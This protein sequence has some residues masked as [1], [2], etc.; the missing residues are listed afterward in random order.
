MKDE[1]NLR[2]LALCTSDKF[3][4]LPNLPQKGGLYSVR[5]IHIIGDRTL[6]RLDSANGSIN[7]CHFSRIA[8]LGPIDRQVTIAELQADGLLRRGRS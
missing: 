8:P 7:A 6:L 1:W 3:K 2:D 4:G 5:G